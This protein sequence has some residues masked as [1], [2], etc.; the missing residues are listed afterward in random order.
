MIRAFLSLF[1]AV[2]AVAMMVGGSYAAFTNSTAN[3]QTYQGGFVALSNSN[4]AWEQNWYSGNMAPGDTVSYVVTVG[5]NGNVPIVFDQGNTNYTKGGTLSDKLSV[6]I[7]PA[8]GN[9][10]TV[11]PAG[12]SKDVRVSATLDPNADNSYQNTT[13]TVTANIAVLSATH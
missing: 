3:T 5:N 2:F 4:S 8:D 1:T 7:N 12:G 10:N 11:I 9:W 13:G 6:S